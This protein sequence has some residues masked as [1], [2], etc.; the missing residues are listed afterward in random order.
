MSDSF[1]K[2]IS[3]LYRAASQDLPPAHLDD[4]ILAAAK[5][6]A[7]AKP[8]SISPF[9][10]KWTLPF[11]LAAAIVLSVSVVTLMEKESPTS[12][13]NN[14]RIS[15][16]AQEKLPQPAIVQDELITKQ[17]PPTEPQ[18][19]LTAKSLKKA[20]P[21]DEPVIHE[22]LAL[23]PEKSLQPSAAQTEEKT[24]VSAGLAKP[25]TPLPSS[26]AATADQ[27]TPISRIN[28]ALKSTVTTQAPKASSSTT[29]TEVSASVNT[30]EPPL[31]IKA[32]AEQPV[33]IMA[34]KEEEEPESSEQLP[35]LTTNQ[36]Q[37]QT[38]A[39]SAS[40]PSSPAE[41]DVSES[42]RIGAS[43]LMSSNKQVT[44]QSCQ[45][46]TARQCLQAPYCTY[47][48]LDSHEI[49]KQQYQ[50]R[51]AANRCEQGFIQFNALAA[52]DAGKSSCESNPGCRFIPGACQCPDGEACDCLGKN[53]PRC[54]EK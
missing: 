34:S 13:D 10:G 18:R 37:L 44:S 27:T 1:D 11:S 48:R 7:Q 47:V 3:A 45:G 29:P 24:A 19:E 22:T 36:N 40:K 51:Q 52:V 6:E 43:A 21:Q 32:E 16:P 53:P 41:T 35:D 17:K 8:K 28:K 4:A 12:G 42:E 15:S 2:E 9:S 23:T 33:S 46:L 50:C 38:F 39:R 20:S 30:K 31:Q 25:S 26:D 5:R 14:M 49:G 54:E